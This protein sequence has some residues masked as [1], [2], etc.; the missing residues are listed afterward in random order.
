MIF[1]GSNLIL[2]SSYYMTTRDILEKVALISF[3]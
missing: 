2:R 1:N 3:V